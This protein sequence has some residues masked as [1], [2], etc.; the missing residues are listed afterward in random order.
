MGIGALLLLLVV[1]F[2]V[3]K[4]F[5]SALMWAVIL[6]YTLFPMQRLFTRWFRGR[7]T[8]AACLVTITISILIAG[9]IVLIGLSLAED[10]KKLANATRTWFLEAP[11]EAPA[12]LSGLPVVGDEVDGYWKA[13]AEDKKR[14]MELLDQQVKAA[15]VE[16]ADDGVVGRTGSP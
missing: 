11:E 4:P 12:W 2:I 1:C 5:L 9:P 13:F 10:G 16:E 14:W 8:I 7:R 3:L 15:P 6:A